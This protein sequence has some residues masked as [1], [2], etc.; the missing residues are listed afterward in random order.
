LE[1][2]F[3]LIA[4]SFLVAT[5]FL[6]AFLVSVKRGQFDDQHTPAVR[7]LFEDNIAKEIK[8]NSKK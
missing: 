2:V 1:V 3:I 8:K 6:V 4:A 7:M 5:G